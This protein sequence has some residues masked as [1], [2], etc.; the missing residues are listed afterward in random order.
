MKWNEAKNQMYYPFY[1]T[2]IWKQNL[3]LK[4]MNEILKKGVNDMKEYKK[5]WGSEKKTRFGWN[6]NNWVATKD[7]EFD[8]FSLNSVIVLVSIL[9]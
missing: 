2:L 9:F 8:F 4:L 5:T 3:R 7:E 1:P 6:G